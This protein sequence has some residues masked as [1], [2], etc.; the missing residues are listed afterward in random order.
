MAE[1][2]IQANDLR[3]SFGSTRAVDGVSLQVSE[4]EIYGLVGPDG[5]G[6]TTLLRLLCGA[7]H[8]DS[9]GAF[10]AGFD[11]ARHVEQ[12]REHIGYLA[13]RFA[14]YEELTVLENLRFFAEV[15]GLPTSQWKPRSQEILAFVGL[16]DFVE[17][18]AGQLSGGMK[19]KL[20]L[21]LALINRPR[22]LLLDEPTT[23]VDPVTR[24]D[25]WRLII[26]LLQEE[27]LCVLV[28]TPYMDEAARCRRVGFL[29]SGKLISEGTPRDLRSILSGRILELSGR[30]QELLLELARSE[31]GVETVQRFGSRFHLRVAEGTSQAILQRLGERIPAAGGSVESLCPIEAQ[32]EDVFIAL[33]EG[34][35]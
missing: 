14:L 3:K 18:R 27:S 16:A 29:R 26:G 10:L 23:G 31:T 35:A 28:S 33:S 12:A 25:F 15:R 22:I 9:G 1:V 8:P 20:G 32:L 21:A 30:P 34:Q 5:A 24:Q 4:G 11:V 19:Q 6:K 7:L 2:L 13:Q 17:R